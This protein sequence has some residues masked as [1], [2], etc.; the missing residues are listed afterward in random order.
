MRG[1]GVN[2]YQG[3]QS[4]KLLEKWGN[5]TNS[6]KEAYQEK[7]E[8]VGDDRLVRVGILLESLERQV[9]FVSE[10]LNESATPIQVSNIGNFKTHAFP[11]ITAIFGTMIAE[12]LVSI[13]P[14]QNKV[15]QVFALEYIYGNTKGKTKKGNIMSG[16]ESHQPGGYDNINYS[17][18]IVEEEVVQEAGSTSVDTNLSYFPIRKGTIVLDVN[19]TTYADNGEG[20]FTG[21]AGVT[22][23]YATGALKGTV[24]GVD[25]NDLMANYEYDL[26]AAP[27]EVPTIDVRVVEKTVTARTRKLRTVYAF[28]AAWE[29]KM[30][31][32]LNM[33]EELLRAVAEEVKHELDGEI[34][35]DLYTQAGL[36]STWNMSAKDPGLAQSDYYKE[37]ISELNSA[38]NSIFQATRRAVG[39]RIV[40]GKLGADVLESIGAPRYVANSGGIQV[41]PH[42]AGILDGKFKVY[43]NP[44]FKE[45]E[46]LIAYKGATFLDAGYIFCPYL[47]FVTTDILMLDD[48]VGR[49]GYVTSNGKK[50]I[51]NK[52]YVKGTIATS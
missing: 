12:D 41:G 11:I 28:N 40:V 1:M 36:T 51:N 17:S 46:Y 45:N 15:A 8:V 50:M 22:I 32:G 2:P 24:A 37:F 21:L 26:E 44:Y 33:D 9:D 42:Y 3:V 52:H 43:K 47:P 38:S 18:E 49:R 6:I 31:Q 34:I 23:D 14:I 20:G 25:T 29:L 30:Q 35:L 5:Y 16:W 10:R 39:N 27:S 48:F 19:G 13:Q 4:E 7:G